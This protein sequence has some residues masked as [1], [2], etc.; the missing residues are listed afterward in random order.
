LTTLAFNATVTGGTGTFN[1]G[2]L[3]VMR[4]G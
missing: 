3:S 2:T 1:S 4:I